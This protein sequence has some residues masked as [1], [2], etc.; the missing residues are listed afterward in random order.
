MGREA[1]VLIFSMVSNLVIAVFKI[2]GGILFQFGSL[3]ADGLQTFSDF[4]TDVVSFLGA[5]FSKKQPTRSHPFGF[6]KV[7]YLTNLFVGVLLLL[8][9]IFIIINGIF[10][11]WHIPELLV[12]WLLIICFI[13]KVIVK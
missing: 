12:L 5:K 9:S 8:L 10:S 6:G 4:V 1:S 2:V 11:T 3:L 13:I 7:E